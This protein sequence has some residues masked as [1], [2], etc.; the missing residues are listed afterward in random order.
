MEVQPFLVYTY[1][2]GWAVQ[3]QLKSANSLL[4]QS[5]FINY[6]RKYKNDMQKKLQLQW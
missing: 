5:M 1:N 4:I 2:K 6:E 3:C